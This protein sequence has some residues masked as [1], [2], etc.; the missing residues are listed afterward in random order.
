MRQVS[1]PASSLRL[2]R[3]RA[4]EALAEAQVGYDAGTRGIESNQYPIP[5][6][7]IES[8]ADLKSI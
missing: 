2:R 1:L 6:S 4:A 5:G 7:C 8:K 3:P